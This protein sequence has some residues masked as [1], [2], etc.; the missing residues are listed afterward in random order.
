MDDSSSIKL[1]PLQTPEKGGLV[2]KNWT[3]IK[4]AID[5]QAEMAA[6]MDNLR[7]EVVAL[8]RMVKSGLFDM[9]PFRIYQL[10]F[11]LRASPDD[12]DWLKFRV[13][14]GRV[15]DLEVDDT[16]GETIPDLD[17]YPDM[18]DIVVDTGVDAHYFWI[19]LSDPSDVKTA[20]LKNGED[21]NSAGWD[22]FPDTDGRFILIG[23]VDTATRESEKIAI[24]RQLLRTDILKG[25]E[26][27]DC[28]GGTET[29]VDYIGYRFD[30]P[31]A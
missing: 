12:D 9:F 25:I 13:R 31:S 21:P 29:P 28:T 7:Q 30:A 6:Q 14:G 19:E 8:R 11:F 22:D 1:P 23:Y 18:T 5:R 17:T 27:F 26:T 4:A 20:T 24:I 16:D 15:G 3:Y 2:E 10:P